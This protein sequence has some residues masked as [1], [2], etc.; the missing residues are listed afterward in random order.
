M[1][2][3]LYIEPDIM[4]FGKLYSFL[5]VMCFGSVDHINRILLDIAMMENC[6]ETSVMLPIGLQDTNGIV[7]ME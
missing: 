3:T 2:S 7:G 4:L 5:N 1:T 6:W